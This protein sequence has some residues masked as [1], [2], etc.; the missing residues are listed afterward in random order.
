MHRKIS[1]RPFLALIAQPW[2][3]RGETAAL[4]LRVSTGGAP[5][6][7]RVNIT[8]ED[9]KPIQIPGATSYTRRD[10]AH[11][12][13]DR[14]VLVNLAPGKYTIDMKLVGIDRSPNVPAVVTIHAN[15]V[16]R[17]D[18]SVDTGLR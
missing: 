9:G 6:V 10:E 2:L 1:R 12:I 14:S 7:A 17:L 5:T 16:T 8:G 13:V 3:L 15:M 11:S 4:N 18:I